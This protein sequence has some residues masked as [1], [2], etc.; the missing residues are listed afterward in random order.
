MTNAVVAGV[1]IAAEGRV[2]RVTYNG[3]T[4]DILVPPDAPIVAFVPGDVSLLH[5]GA[6][7]ALSAT[8]RPDGTVTATRAT[9]EKDGVKPPM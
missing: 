6:A 9:V 2:L 1:T 4:A 3:S 5:P 7:I 8:R